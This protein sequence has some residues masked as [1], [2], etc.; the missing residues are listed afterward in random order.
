MR[1]NK[2]GAG[3]VLAAAIL[4]TGC[5][6]P[7]DEPKDD[8]ASSTPAAEESTA[9]ASDCP[10]LA[11][12][13]TVDGATLAECVSAAMLASEGF[14]AK[15]TTLGME[16][17]TKFNPGDEALETTTTFG[18]IIAIGDDAWVKTT[19]GEWQ[20][21][22]PASSDQMVSTLSTAAKATDPADPMGVAA[23]LSGE[24]TVTGKSTRLGQ[25]VYLV[26]GTTE[27]Q[28]TTVN[29]VFELTK[30]YVALAAT[31]STEVQ[32]QKLESVQEITEWDVKQDIVAPL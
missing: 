3:I 18:S 1:V 15:M 19:D 31:G 24:Y 4:L 26:S 20:V 2:I 22:D 28:G 29:M 13:A 9:P 30:D 6:A 10:E 25:D 7:A 27:E 11:E 32:G 17:T 16:S 23:S 5:S 12:G 8:T 21:A 14:A